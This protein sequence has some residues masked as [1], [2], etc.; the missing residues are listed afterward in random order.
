MTQ[1][2]YESDLPERE[3]WIV[4]VDRLPAP[5]GASAGTSARGVAGH[6]IATVACNSMPSSQYLHNSDWLFDVR[7]VLLHEI[8]HPFGLVP[9]GSR[10]HGR[11]QGPTIG[12]SIIPQPW[13]EGSH[14]RSNDC[15]MN[16][17]VDS[18][19]VLTT[20]GRSGALAHGMTIRFCGDQAPN[21]CTLFLRARD[22]QGILRVPG[23]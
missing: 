18:A 10:V 12:G 16:A 17:S 13:N 22:L 3:L 5:Q 7:R 2:I 14:C 15:T 4:A 20:V 19:V 11:T 6:T 21:A 1:G 8:G 9:S 23:L